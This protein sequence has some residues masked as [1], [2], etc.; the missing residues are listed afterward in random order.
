[1]NPKWTTEEMSSYRAK[2]S[3]FLL[4][5]TANNE[6]KEWLLNHITPYLSL[7]KNTQKYKIA[8]IVKD[9]LDILV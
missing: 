9:Y 2:R 6:Q 8:K 3:L 5:I 4:L 7:R 1:M